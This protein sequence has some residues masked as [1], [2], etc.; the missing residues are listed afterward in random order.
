MLELYHAFEVVRVRSDQ[1]GD[2][3]LQLGYALISVLRL[4]GHCLRKDRP[5]GV[6]VLLVRSLGNSPRQQ[7]LEDQFPQL[8][9][10]LVALLLQEHLH[11]YEVCGQ[12]CEGQLGRLGGGLVS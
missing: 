4:V 10:R 8:L 1:L 6:E 2:G 9:V 3:S 12:G 5:Q 11:G 7:L